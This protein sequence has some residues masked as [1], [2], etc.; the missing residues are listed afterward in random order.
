MPLQDTKAAQNRPELAT[1]PPKRRSEFKPGE[2]CFIT[3]S[4]HPLTCSAVPG[5]PHHSTRTGAAR[6]AQTSSPANAQKRAKAS[7]GGTRRS[8]S[9]LRQRDANAALMQLFASVPHGARHICYTKL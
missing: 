7:V 1:T 8:H 9:L 5:G 2:H 6:P 4:L 3:Y